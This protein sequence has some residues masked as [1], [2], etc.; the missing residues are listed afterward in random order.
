[1]YRESGGSNHLRNPLSPSDL[2]FHM[3][4]TPKLCPKRVDCEPLSRRISVSCG[5]SGDEVVVS[6]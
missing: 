3:A 4:S 2:F 5:A 6:V 1:M